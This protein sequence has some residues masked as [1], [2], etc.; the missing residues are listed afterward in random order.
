MT[1]VSLDSFDYWDNGIINLYVF[2]LDSSLDINKMAIQIV[3]SMVSINLNRDNFLLQKSLFIHILRKYRVLG[4]VDV[5][6]D[7]SGKLNDRV[8]AKYGSWS[9]CYSRVLIL[10]TRGWSH[11]KNIL[12]S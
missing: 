6:R 3:N 5:L 10:N 11:E 4:I 7:R 9:K 1:Y 8:N 12:M 2:H